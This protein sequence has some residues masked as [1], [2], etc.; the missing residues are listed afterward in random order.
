MRNSR[1]GMAAKDAE[2]V[3]SSITGDDPPSSSHSSSGHEVTV[4]GDTVRHYS[5][6]KAEVSYSASEERCKIIE[7]GS[8]PASYGSINGQDGE[9]AAEVRKWSG[10]RVYDAQTGRVHVVT[11][12]KV[13]Q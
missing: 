8:A 13:F 11:Q 5:P 2:V 10:V 6:Q 12:G 1:G 9:A 3:P 7:N 4:E